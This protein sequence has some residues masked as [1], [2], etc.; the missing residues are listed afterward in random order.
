MTDLPKLPL[1]PDNTPWPI[2][3]WPLGDVPA[4]ADTARLNRLIDYAFTPVLPDDLRETHALVI[5]HRGKLVAERYGAGIGPSDTLPSWSIAKSITQ[6]LVGLVVAD[7]RI[8][9]HAPAPVPEWPAG[10]PR[11]AITTDLLLRMSSGLAFVEEYRPDQPSDTIVML[12]GDGKDDVARYAAQKPL[13]HAP[14][15]F[16]AY[17]SGSANL[18]ARAASLALDKSGPDLEAY[19]RAR[20]FDPLDMA[21]AVPKLDAAGTFIG[22]S[23]CFATARDF[24]RFGLLYLRGGVWDGTRILPQGW[25][26][27]A[28]TATVQQPTDSARYGACWWLD[29]AGPGSFSANGFQGQYIVAVPDRDLVIVRLGATPDEALQPVK[30]WIRA[31]AECFPR[32]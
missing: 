7:G 6:A 5:V 14:G 24:A 21:S 4:G 32:M 3:D 19:L 15:T 13:E 31:V 29:L 11:R 1:Q 20:L 23:Y 12:F 18:A 8:D 27:Y 25:V 28:R 2:K 9:I 16:W 10:D 22:S 26:D 17:S 30:D